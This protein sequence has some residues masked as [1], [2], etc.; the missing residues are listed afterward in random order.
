MTKKV[1][2]KLKGTKEH[3][4]NHQALELLRRQRVDEL[5]R[6]IKRKL[7][8]FNIS[9][10]D[11]IDINVIFPINGYGSDVMVKS[12]YIRQWAKKRLNASVV[13]VGGNKLA[14]VKRCD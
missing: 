14:F 6:G 12:T 8:S 2:G 11:I 1:N 7:N 13:S 9:Y 3:L 10:E 4:D 5:E